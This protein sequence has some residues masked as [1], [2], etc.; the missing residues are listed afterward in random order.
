MSP[1][2]AD[3]A[4]AQYGADRPYLGPVTGDAETAQADYRANPYGPATF[5]PPGTPSQ[6]AG[7]VW[8]ETV[9][10]AGGDQD[11]LGLGSGTGAG[12]GDVLGL[13]S[14]PAPRFDPSPIPGVTTPFAAPGEAPLTGMQR[15]GRVLE[16]IG[17]G[18]SGAVPAYERRAKAKR[19]EARQGQA[20]QL[21]KLKAAID[22]FES[23]AKFKDPATRQAMAPIVKSLIG[24]TGIQV[25]DRLFESLTSASG[26]A[27][28]LGAY[29]TRRFG[30]KAD[31]AW[32]MVS[33][34]EDPTKRLEAINKIYDTEV[35]GALPDLQRELAG[36]A[37]QMRGD[38]DHLARLGLLDETG[39]PK[40]IPLDRFESEVRQALEGDPVKA[41]AFNRLVTDP[42][43]AGWWAGMGVEPGAVRLKGFE[44]TTTEM[45]K[46]A[47]PG[48]RATLRKTQAEAAATE[49][50]KVVP[51]QQGGGVMRVPPTGKAEIVVPPGP[52]APSDSIREGLAE[53]R[54]ALNTLKALQPRVEKDAGRYF[55]YANAAAAAAARGGEQIGAGTAKADY[56]K[57]HAD[58]KFQRAQLLRALEKGNIAKSDIDFF[59]AGWP[60]ATDAPTVAVQR[61]RAAVEFAEAKLAAKEAEF[62]PSGQTGGPAA[63]PEGA[64]LLPDQG[65]GY[66]RI[67]LPD[68]SVRKRRK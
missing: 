40:P 46:E 52:K 59:L 44:T 42:K 11:L 36:D 54:G 68:G 47:T 18:Y 22:A 31:Q 41:D 28:K 43:Y 64:T 34:I 19:E 57:F 53:A 30:P 1:S 49:A 32:D 55:G 48:G 13:G 16:D 27:G 14:G 23:L 4:M 2:D 5:V 29:L 8:P 60:D 66:E 45:A 35:E 26:T 58:L 65:D 63:P 10:V 38:R 50:G 39:R 3:T 62:R 25:N 33:D 51:F 12:P 21:A 56:E 9:G 6:P 61:Y 15:F 37:R 20:D 24:A 17:A 67:R 7:G